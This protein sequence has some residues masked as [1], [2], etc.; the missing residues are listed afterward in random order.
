[1]GQLLTTEY[2]EYAR[3]RIFFNFKP[4]LLLSYKKNGEIIINLKN[5]RMAVISEFKNM[6]GVTRIFCRKFA[7][8]V[9]HLIF[10]CLFNHL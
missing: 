2:I 4:P 9:V 8:V 5:K 6:Y 7:K 3:Q 1:M 10:E